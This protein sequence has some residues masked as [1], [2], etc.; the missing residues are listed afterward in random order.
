M[1]QRFLIALKALWPNPNRRLEAAAREAY[2]LLVVCGQEFHPTA[3]ELRAALP[4]PPARADQ[5]TLF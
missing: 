4:A 2:G 1:F 5:K 3:R